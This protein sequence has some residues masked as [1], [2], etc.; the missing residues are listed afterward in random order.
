MACGAGVVAAVVVGIIVVIT[1]VIILLFARSEL[2]RFV[3]SFQ[4]VRFIANQFG[5]LNSGEIVRS[6][7]HALG[8]WT[9]SLENERKIMEGES[10]G[11]DPS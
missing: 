1:T 4:D 6:G 9:T 3:N 10:L 7:K 11:S 5:F 2:L 8:G